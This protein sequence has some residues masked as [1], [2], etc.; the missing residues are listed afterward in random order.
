MKKEN[1][2]MDKNQI[3]NEIFSNDPLNLLEVK[4]KSSIISNDDRLL[5]SFEEINDF[6]EKNNHEPTKSSDRIERQLY[7]RLQ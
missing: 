6:Y 5:N 2:Q 3:L 1:K 4:A 7:S